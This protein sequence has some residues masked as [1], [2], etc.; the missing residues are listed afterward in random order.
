MQRYRNNKFWRMK[1]DDEGQYVSYEDVEYL[2]NKQ[3]QLKKDN[4]LLWKTLSERSEEIKEL[5]SDI[6]YWHAR[7]QYWRDNY[8]QAS[9]KK[10][11]YAIKN[12][13]LAWTIVILLGLLI[14]PLMV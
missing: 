9:S 12:K 1:P 6:E 14:L 2:L 13:Q 10:R 7:Q 4:D 11:R 5:T 3:E 8:L